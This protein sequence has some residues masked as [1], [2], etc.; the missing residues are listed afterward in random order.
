MQQL[1]EQAN[2]DEAIS[3][4]TITQAQKFA[5]FTMLKGK[6]AVD[7]LQPYLA[8]LEKSRV[9]IGQNLSSPYAQRLYLHGSKSEQTRNAFA[10][11]KH[12][13][14]E[15]RQYNISSAQAVVESNVQSVGLAPQNEESYQNALKANLEK[16]QQ[17]AQMSG[18]DSVWA[19]NY[20]R[21]EN[22]RMTLNR[23][24]NLA[25]MDVAGAQKLIDAASA[26]KNLFGEDLGKAQDF[27]RTQRLS[28]ATRQEAARAR[29][30][31]NTS[32]GDA[33]L[34]IDQVMEAVAGNE[35][36]DYGTKHPPV[37]HKVNGK[38]TTEYGLGRWGV[39]Q[40]NLQPWLK[41]AG[42]KPMTEQEFLNSPEAQKQLVKF[43]LQQ[44]QEEGGSANAA[45]MKWFTGDYNPDPSRNDKISNAGQYKQRFNANLFRQGGASFADAAGRAR[46]KQLFGDDAEAEEAMSQHF[47]TVNNRD[48][49]LAREDLQDNIDTIEDALVPAKNGKL[50][51]SIEDVQDPKVQAA[52][53]A[54]PA[55][56]Q[57]KYRELM[58]RN[59]RNEYR[60]TAEN[61]AEYRKWLSR[62]TDPMA[63]PEERREAMNQEY[64]FMN[65]PANQR[66]QLINLK[67]AMW[68]SDNKAQN[69]ALN[70]A[71]S[72]SN[73]ILRQA[74][75]D[76][77]KT[78][79][80]YDLIRGT[81]FTILQQ[82]AADGNPVK[83]DQEYREITSGLVR[84]VNQYRLYGFVWGGTQAFK[85]EVP[86]SDKKIITDSYMQRYD[87][88]PTSKEI[89][90]IYNA[91]MYNQLYNKAKKMQSD[92]NAAMGPTSSMAPQVPRSQ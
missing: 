27:V 80:D 37:T 38:T 78:K 29:S 46:S 53:D 76:R 51:T 44:F 34:P 71:M 73:D 5:D 92:K 47:V 10:V 28:V 22:S 89:Q 17:I 6:Q 8:D 57:N 84:Q 14:D 36:A 11:A 43:K 19:E 74:G 61:Q 23:V 40:S 60:E 79:E 85:V 35:G 90:E 41:E 64:A 32:L 3:K 25:R 18:K 91:K 30:G 4:F 56:Q 48:K 13:G 75:I 86:E 52:W 59:A 82:R 83:N 33:K 15:G 45:A 21:A 26:S 12:A 81:M 16:A 42:M 68:K 77:T 67:R 62:L 58:G 20:A 63:S 65:L 88:E 1:N 24:R 72:V 50:V 54:L 2:A 87:R 31:D 9:E 69:P 55:R 39:M 7:G 49:Q 66:Q 70:H